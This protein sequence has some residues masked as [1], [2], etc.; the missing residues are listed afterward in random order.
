MGVSAAD[1]AVIKENYPNVELIADTGA[2]ITDVNPGSPAEKAGLKVKDVVTSVDGKAI[3][4]SSQLV[5]TLLAYESG[6][7]IK[8]VFLRDGVEQETNLTLVLQS[9][10]SKIEEEENPFKN[11]PTAEDRGRS[12]SGNSSNPFGW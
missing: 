6:D 11:P 5:K 10:M 2:V 12:G 8:V 7:T 9:E 3:S 4:G 1:V